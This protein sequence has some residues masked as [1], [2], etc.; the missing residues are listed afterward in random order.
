[1]IINYQLSPVPQ[2]CCGTR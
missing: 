2:V 1:M